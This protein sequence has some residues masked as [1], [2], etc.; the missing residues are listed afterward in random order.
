MIRKS[1]TAGCLTAHA[2][3]LNAFMAARALALALNERSAERCFYLDDADRLV[4][5][6]HVDAE[7]DDAVAVAE[8]GL[9]EGAVLLEAGEFNALGLGA[10]S[11]A[12]DHPNEGAVPVVGDGR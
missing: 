12:G 5:V 6:E 1:M 8:A 3:R 4:R 11:V 7:R 10:V 9:D 2:D